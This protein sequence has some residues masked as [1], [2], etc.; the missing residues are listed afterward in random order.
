MLSNYNCSFY[1]PMYIDGK[2]RMHYIVKNLI[3]FKEFKMSIF[4]VHTHWK[5]NAHKKYIVISHKC[6]SNSRDMVTS[7]ESGSDIEY[8]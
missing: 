7:Q 3:S 5:D 6:R 8:P 2:C 4:S 1:I